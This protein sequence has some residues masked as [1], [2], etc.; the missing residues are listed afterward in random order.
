MRHMQDGRGAHAHILMPDVEGAGLGQR[1]GRIPDRVTG[2]NQGFRMRILEP[3]QY[4][5]GAH[6]SMCRL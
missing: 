4:R 2:E 6:F 5:P 1:L 3:G